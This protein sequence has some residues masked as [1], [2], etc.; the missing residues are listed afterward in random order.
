MFKRRLR[1]DSEA[2]SPL[3]HIAFLS[4]RSRLKNPVYESPV[5][6]AATFILLWFGSRL[7]ATMAEETRAWTGIARRRRTTC[8]AMLAMKDS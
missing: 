8:R 1:L 7:M 5:V 6:D 2:A 3:G 4:S